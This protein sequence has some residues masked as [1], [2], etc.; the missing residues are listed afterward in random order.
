MINRKARKKPKPGRQQA[1]AP[2]CI[3]PNCGRPRYA[4]G[5]CQAHHRQLITTGKLKPIRPYRK[6]SPG[7]IKFSGLRLSEKAAKEVD[8]KAAREGLS[9]GAVIASIL[10]EWGRDG[11]EPP[12]VAR[13]S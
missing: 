6:R 7:T 13:A 11:A 4:R 9:R 1:Q 3:V 5:C 8:G 2:L 12:A 10:E